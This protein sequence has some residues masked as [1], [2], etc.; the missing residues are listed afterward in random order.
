MEIL[1]SKNYCDVIS[2]DRNKAFGQYDLR[3]GYSSRL[4]KA[5]GIALSIVTG[6]FSVAFLVSPKVTASDNE[7]IAQVPYIMS[8]EAVEIYE[9]L[10]KNSDA[11]KSPASKQPEPL[12]KARSIQPP[13]DGKNLNFEI[14]K[15]QNDQID[16]SAHPENKD[17]IDKQDFT[18]Q[19]AEVQNA[20]NPG[21]TE[22]GPHSGNDVG[23]GNSGEVGPD[24]FVDFAEVDPVF[25]GDLMSFIAKSTRYPSDAVREG[26]E[27]KVMIC[28]VVDERGK[29]TKPK[30][31]HGIGHGCDEEALR[32]VGTLPD[33]EPGKMNGKAVKVRMR[34]PF[35]FTLKR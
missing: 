17:L 8:P 10:K 19:N 16:T 2:T 32:V 26:V 1:F 11:D 5:V 15:I 34:V 22:P 31:E 7:K 4:L 12:P 13:V 35:K 33:F 23:G 28:F 29:V 6:L 24:G 14:S 30:I 3:V 18:D 21:P 20:G 9:F 27:G 25:K